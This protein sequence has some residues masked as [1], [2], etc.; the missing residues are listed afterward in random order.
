[1]AVWTALGRLI[2]V[3]LA[4]LLGAAA[5]LFVLVTLGLERITHALSGRIEDAG[6]L[7]VLIELVLQGGLLV[8]GLTILPALL[9]AIVGEIARIRSVLYYVVGGG[10]AM[11][12]TPLIAG[13]VRIG[14]ETLPEPV[15]W[16][17]FATAGFLGGLVYWLLAGRR[18]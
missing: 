5:A 14:V 1:M 10:L 12:A 11:C 4:F 7:A 15:V 9:V 13:A 6:A 18:A 8:S 3:P 2:V 17:V 16:Q